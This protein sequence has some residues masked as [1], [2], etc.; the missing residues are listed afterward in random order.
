MLLAIGRRGSPRNLGVPGEEL[1]K[2]VYELI[3]AEQY[4]GRR[5]L[6][7]GGGDSALEAA[8]MLADQPGALVTLSYRAPHFSRARQVNRERVQALAAQGRLHILMPSDVTR[9]THHAVEI[10]SGGAA[11]TLP[12][13]AVVICA[14]GVPPTEF[15]RR[16][17]VAMETKYGTR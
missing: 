14:G 10:S 2:V 3:E 4:A 8:Q 1:P 17:G 13:D 7:V 11:L 15:L 5:V 12:N 16:T 6:V 9:I